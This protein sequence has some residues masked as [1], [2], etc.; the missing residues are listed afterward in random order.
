M[1]HAAMVVEAGRVHRQCRCSVPI[2]SFA[3]QHKRHDSNLQLAVGISGYKHTAALLQ[4][5]WTLHGPFRGPF[6]GHYITSFAATLPTNYPSRRL[7]PAAPLPPNGRHRY[8][9]GTRVQTRLSPSLT[10]WQ[11]GRQ[12]VPYRALRRPW[13]ASCARSSRAPLRLRP[14]AAAPPRQKRRN[15]LHGRR[16]GRAL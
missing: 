15:S 13:T 9:A 7:L 2:K 1:H 12:C 14:Q 4:A 16:L 10:P 8:P 3:R 5:S 11:R 6:A